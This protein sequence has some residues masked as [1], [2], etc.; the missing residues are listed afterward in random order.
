MSETEA[1]FVEDMMEQGDWAMGSRMHRLALLARRGAEAAAEIE[2][3]NRE[4]DDVW[5]DLAI[6][7]E[8]N[9]SFGDAFKRMTSEIERLRAALRQ[10][11]GWIDNWDCAFKDDP[12]WRQ[13]APQIRAALAQEKA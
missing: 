4:L 2:R 8:D 5:D 9:A 10:A 6:Q 12:E 1:E 3:L 7:R 11:L 13:Y